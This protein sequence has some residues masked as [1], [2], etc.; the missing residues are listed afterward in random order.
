VLETKEA[1]PL[2]ATRPRSVNFQLCAATLRDLR[3]EVAAGRFRE[4]LYHRVGRPEVSI[5]SLV[6]RREEIPWLAVRELRRLDERI[7]PTASFIEA[8]LLRDWPG[9]VR[10]FLREMQES[11]LSASADARALLYAADLQTRDGDRSE[12]GSLSA[13]P[14]GDDRQ[15]THSDDDI[16]AAIRAAGGNVSQAARALTMHRNQLRRWLAANK[17]DINTLRDR[18]EPPSLRIV[19]DGSQTPESDD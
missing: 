12:G 11:A 19:P 2:G 18:S 4:D 16:R 1:L 6:E 5:P 10:E 15:S 14:A 9:N 7:G 13:G 17:V 3:R 8:C